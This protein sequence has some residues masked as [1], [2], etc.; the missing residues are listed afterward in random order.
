MSDK[1]EKELAKLVSENPGLS[2]TYMG[3]PTPHPV[4]KCKVHCSLTGLDILGRVDVVKSHLQSRR[5]KLA[6]ENSEEW[7][8]ELEGIVQDRNNENKLHCKVTGYYSHAICFIS[9]FSLLSD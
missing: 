4:F 3:L 7:W 5:Y 2:F 8:E 1:E 6:K 9:L